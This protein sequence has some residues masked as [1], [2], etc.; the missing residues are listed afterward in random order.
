MVKKLAGDCWLSRAPSLD[1]F[2]I[3]LDESHVL[4]KLKPGK[5]VVETFSSAPALTYLQRKAKLVWCFIA[6]SVFP[7]LSFYP[8]KISTFLV[9]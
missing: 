9:F 6:R 1:E 2:Q 4:M 8:Y 7:V 5:K 3:P